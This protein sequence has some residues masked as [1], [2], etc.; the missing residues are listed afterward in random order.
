MAFEVKTKVLYLKDEDLFLESEK[1]D[2]ND[3]NL[4]D[5][6]DMISV[7][8]TGVAIFVRGKKRRILKSRY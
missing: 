8:H 1:K 7:K 3:I 6:K 2:I 4:T 5:V